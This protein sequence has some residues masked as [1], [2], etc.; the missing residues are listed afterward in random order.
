MTA[1][2]YPHSTLCALISKYLKSLAPDVWFFRP[3]GMGYGRTGIPDFIVCRHGQFLAL[4]AKSGRDTVKPWQER[5][6]AA[7][8]AAGGA[9][10]VV[11]ELAD[12]VR[13][14]EA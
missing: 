4:E 10:L 5:E 6:L 14:M 1:V 9:A 13:I 12:V 8:Q 11:R 2:I 7:I 3:T